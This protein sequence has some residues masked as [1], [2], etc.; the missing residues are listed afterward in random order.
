MKHAGRARPN[1]LVSS[2]ERLAMEKR[3]VSLASLEVQI[4]EILEAVNE[5]VRRHTRRKI[6]LYAERKRLFHERAALLA[7]LDVERINRARRFIAVYGNYDACFGERDRV[8]DA[9]ADDIAHGLKNLRARRP[10]IKDYGSFVGQ[11]GWL[12][13]GYKPSHG[14]VVFEIGLDRDFTDGR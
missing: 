9:A 11:F 4:T 8:I 13:Y 1:C 3:Q 12:E 5:E 10:F 7:G 6:E 2:T 14:H